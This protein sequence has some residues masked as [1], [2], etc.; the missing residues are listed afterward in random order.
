MR[1]AIAVILALPRDPEIDDSMNFGFVFIERWVRLI[2]TRDRIDES[3]SAVTVV[4]NSSRRSPEPLI[5]EVIESCPSREGIPNIPPR[6]ALTV[7]TDAV[8]AAGV[9]R[10]SMVSSAVADPASRVV[11]R[12]E[13]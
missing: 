9:T 12:T 7:F 6:L 1:V 11:H 2:G 4:V 13:L 8:Y 3:I 5:V 10:R